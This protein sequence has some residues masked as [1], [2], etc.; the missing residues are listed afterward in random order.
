MLTGPELQRSPRVALGLAA[1]AVVCIIANKALPAAVDGEYMT[2]PHLIQDEAKVVAEDVAFCMSKDPVSAAFCR[3]DLREG[4][5]EIMG[6]VFEA[7]SRCDFDAFPKKGPAVKLDQYV[8]N[9]KAKQ[10]SALWAAVSPYAKQYE[11]SWE[12]DK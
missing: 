1:V 10:D 4:R 12:K 5:A 2:K 8:K 9:M 3:A 11:S 7:L 6:E